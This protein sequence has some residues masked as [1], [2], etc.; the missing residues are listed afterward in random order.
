MRVQANHVLSTLGASITK[1]GAHLLDAVKH[2]ERGLFNID[3]TYVPTSAEFNSNFPSRVS[4]RDNATVDDAFFDSVYGIYLDWFKNNIP[5]LILDTDSAADFSRDY[6]QYNAH[7]SYHEYLH[8]RHLIQVMP[9][10]KSSSLCV[11]H[12]YRRACF[13]HWQLHCDRLD[14]ELVWNA[15]SLLV[16]FVLT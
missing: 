5:Q 15:H 7:S 13:L 11:L 8:D 16:S 3:Q 12:T 14:A 1:L 6:A 4:T 10:A 2:C 9:F